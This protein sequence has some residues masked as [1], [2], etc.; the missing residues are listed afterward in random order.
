VKSG[1]GTKRAMKKRYLL[2]FPLLSLATAGAG[3]LFFSCR[4]SPDFN[5]LRREILDL[6]LKT[7]AAHWK[8]DPGFFTA[9]MADGYF[10]VQ[11]G[12]VRRPTRQEIA[13][14]YERYL[15]TTT[16]TEYRDLQ[17]PLIGFSKDGS[18]AWSVVRV[19]VAGSQRE[20]TGPASEF[21]LVW[22]WITLYE[23]KD[24]RW[25]WLGEASTFKPAEK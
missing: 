5:A 20:G 12:E 3:C 14:E 9:H 18:V 24:G 8:K 10:A 19:K 15:G 7:I 21:D 11:K 17:E 6:H 1:Q 16:F 2:V 25:V 4:P 22:A 23:R 13:A